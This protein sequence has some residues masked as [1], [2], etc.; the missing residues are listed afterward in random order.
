MLNHDVVVFTVSEIITEGSVIYF[1]IFE[2]RLIKI[3]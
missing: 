1:V 3:N 2:G